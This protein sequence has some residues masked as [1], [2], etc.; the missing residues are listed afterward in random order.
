[1]IKRVPQ[2]PVVV[3]FDRDETERLQHTIWH[4]PHGT[5]NLGHSMH[6]TSLGLECNLDEI[7]LHQRLRNLQQPAGYGNGLQLSFGAPSV[8]QTNCS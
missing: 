4:V 2:T 8:F 7:S 5:E 3:V 1:M 6:G